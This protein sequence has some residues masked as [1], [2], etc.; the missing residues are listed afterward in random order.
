MQHAEPGVLIRTWTISV[1]LRRSVDRLECLIVPVAF[2][3]VHPASVPIQL[4]R[5]RRTYE[6]A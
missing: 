3:T 2:G 4:W 5:I 6:E 1:T